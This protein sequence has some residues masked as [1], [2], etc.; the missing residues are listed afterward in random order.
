MSSVA[1]VCSAARLRA[2][3]WATRGQ[4]LLFGGL[5][6]VWGVHIPS[7]KAHYALD[8]SALSLALLA[9][10][11]GAVLCLTMAGRIVSRLGARAAALFAGMLMSAALA[12]MLAPSG[13]AA[14]IALVLI[15]GGA[16]ALFDVAINAEGSALEAVSG[17][18]VMGGFHGMF[19]LG[20]MAGAARAAMPIRA[21]VPTAL[22]ASARS[23]GRR[24]WA[25]SPSSAR[26]PGG[27]A[28]RWWSVRC[29]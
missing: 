4:F 14:L 25:E 28:W 17:K 1:E 21:D 23:Q 3:R 10:A 18:K 27:S 2:A 24:W 8:A 11:V 19:S 16:F 13:F 29:C 20:G 15:F 26:S 6:G 7:V 9:L 12:A 22:P 5:T